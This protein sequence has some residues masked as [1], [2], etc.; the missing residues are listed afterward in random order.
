MPRFLTHTIVSFRHLICRYLNTNKFAS[1]THWS[2]ICHHTLP[3][4][5]WL[6]LEYV[7]VHLKESG[8]ERDIM[9]WKKSI[10]YYDQYK[11]SCT[12]IEF[13]MHTIYVSGSGFCISY[14]EI[15]LTPHINSIRDIITL[16]LSWKL[17]HSF[18]NEGKSWKDKHD[19]DEIRLCMYNTWCLGCLLC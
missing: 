7:C 3:I 9:I 14:V 19:A 10:L 18:S 5:E 16:S 4:L 15:Y 17:R 1:L 11:N 8:K 2:F 12:D 6:G 13:G